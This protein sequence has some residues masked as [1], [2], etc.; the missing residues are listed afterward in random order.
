MRLINSS[1]GPA[2]KECGDWI[3]IHD[4]KPV[5]KSGCPQGEQELTLPQ[6]DSLEDGP[7][8]GYDY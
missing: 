3:E 5:C 6:L 4:G 7:I 8:D 2:C 1:D